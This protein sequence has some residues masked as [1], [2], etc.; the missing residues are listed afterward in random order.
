MLGANS[1]KGNINQSENPK[2]VSHFGGI[3]LSC[4]YNHPFPLEG[5]VQ[6]FSVE[7]LGPISSKEVLNWKILP[8]NASQ[9][10]SILCTLKP[11]CY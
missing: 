9:V 7:G 8:Y 5:C 2:E 1:D 3:G 11:F 4:S 6:G 10:I